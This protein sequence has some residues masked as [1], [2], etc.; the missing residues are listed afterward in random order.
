MKIAF[1]TDTFPPQINSISVSLLTLCEELVNRGH[2]VSVFTTPERDKGENNPP[3]PELLKVFRYSDF[4][5]HSFKRN[6]Q[7]IIH[8]DFREIFSSKPD[9]IH[10]HTPFAIGKQG[11]R[12][13]QLLKVPLIGSHHTFYANYHPSLLENRGA[14][15]DYLI[16]KRVTKFYNQCQLVICPSRAI[17]TEIS[18]HKLKTPTSI[19]PHPIDVAK[20]KPFAP[21]SDL[22]KFFGLPA[23]T[24][25]P[26][27]SLVY[28]GKLSYEKRI[29]ELLKVFAFLSPKYPKMRLSIIGD[30]PERKNLEEFSERLQIREKVLFLGLLTGQTFVDAIAANDIFIT[31]SDAENQPLPI[32]E[33]MALG[34]PQVVAKSPIAEYIEYGVTGLV[35]EK[36]SFMELSKEIAKLIENPSMREKMSESSKKVAL[37]YDV[38]N[39]A[40]EHEIIYKDFCIS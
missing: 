13:A 9:I 16:K 22:K 38:K 26:D 39:I 36:Y 31:A 12:A 6:G 7:E 21:K 24:G 32:F 17:A 28:M 35:T 23:Q 18:R 20:L 4:L 8:K 10:V 2:D 40:T 37:K 14:L 3:M 11:V 30:G 5:S 29:H 19:I 1:F 15:A 33:A 34:L 27:I 25:L